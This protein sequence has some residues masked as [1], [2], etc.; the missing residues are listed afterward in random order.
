MTSIRYRD[1]N[2]SIHEF[3]LV[4]LLPS[5]TSQS[6]SI[7]CTIEYTS[8]AHPPPYTAL[9]Y[10][11]GDPKDVRAIVVNGSVCKAR[12]NLVNA[13]HELRRSNVDRLWIDA[14]CINQHDEYEKGDQ[15]ALIGTI[16]KLAEKVIAWLGNNPEAYDK[17]F[18]LMAHLEK[19]A[20]TRK[21]PHPRPMRAIEMGKYLDPEYRQSLLEFFE[22]PY[23]TRVWIIQEI[24][25]GDTVELACGSRR[26]SLGQVSNTVSILRKYVVPDHTA[27]RKA[28]MNQPRYLLGYDSPFQPPQGHHLIEDPIFHH[29]CTIIDTRYTTQKAEPADLVTLM[30]RSV[31]AESTNP[32]DQAYGLFGL[33]SS[34]PSPP[35]VSG[36]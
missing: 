23:W 27:W 25:F 12:A 26:F 6:G 9:S 3:R 21:K 10:V 19:T 2:K 1:L 24:A 18:Q 33:V 29:I 4:R 30:A 28:A 31:R 32:M 36:G 11:W 8:L 15:I 17:A 5:I 13:L 35:L 22:N 16:Y 7:H 14:L 20:P 34:I